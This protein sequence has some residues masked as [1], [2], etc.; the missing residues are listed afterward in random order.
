MD[1]LVG[2]TLETVLLGPLLD[3]RLRF[4]SADG[5]PHLVSVGNDE[6][7]RALVARGAIART[8]PEPDR[9]REVALFDA[10]GGTLFVIERLWG[11]GQQ[12]IVASG[13]RFTLSPATVSSDGD[14]WRAAAE[15]WR[16]AF[17]NAAARGEFV[18]VE[19]GGWEQGSV[20]YALA[21]AHRGEDGAWE[22]VLEAAPAPSSGMWPESGGPGSTIRA[23]MSPATLG[24]SGMLIADAVQAWTATPFDTVI[25]YGASPDGALELPLSSAQ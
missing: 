24:V 18:V 5:A 10:S 6:G 25:T 7:L 9:F 12:P 16:D 3:G 22:S 4:W 1:E 11:A 17:Q 20:P 2:A 8:S 15:W 21:L 23:P 13:G 14:L 19:P